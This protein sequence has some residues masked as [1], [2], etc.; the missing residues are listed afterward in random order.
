MKAHIVN[1]GG[2]REFTQI[3]HCSSA[4]S[5][6]RSFLDRNNYENWGNW[7]QQTDAVM[8]QLFQLQPCAIT[9]PQ[10]ELCSLLLHAP[11]HSS[12]VASALEPQQIFQ[13]GRSRAQVLSQE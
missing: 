7:A 5:F 9:F 3:P 2:R 1:W 4:A 12:H 8:G 11:S 13:Q 10:G 6:G